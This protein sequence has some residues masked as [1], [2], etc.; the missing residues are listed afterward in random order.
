MRKVLWWGLSILWIA[1]IVGLLTGVF[2]PP[3]GRM[4]TPDMLI[5]NVKIEGETVW[6]GVHILE[7]R[8]GYINYTIEPLENGDFEI[9]EISY[10]AV[11]MMGVNQKVISHFMTIV[12]STLALKSFE[13]FVETDKYAT[14]FS[15]LIEDHVLGIKLTTGNEKTTDKFMP[16]PEPIYISYALKSLMQ[17]GKLRDDDSLK[18][19]SFDPLTM[20][21]RDIMV[22]SAPLKFHPIENQLVEA[23][24][25][26]L[27]TY[28]LE[29]KMYVDAKGE[30][31]LET[32]PMGLTM[33]RESREDAMN[34]ASGSNAK[35]DFLDLFAVKPKGKIN[36]PRDNN[37]L[38]LKVVGADLSMLQSASDRQ[39]IID[40]EKGLAEIRR[41]PFQSG[42]LKLSFEKT[43]SPEPYIESDDLHIIAK[44]QE[45]V[46]G[47]KT[48]RD[49]LDSITKWVFKS[50][51]KKPSAGI[52]SAIAV[53]QELSGDCNEHAVL[54]TALARAVGIPTTVQLGVVYQEDKFF[55]HA[56]TASYVD[57]HWLE[58]DPTFNQTVADPSRIAFAS[59]SMSDAAKLASIIGNLKIDVISEQ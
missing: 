44:A 22:Y 38:T 12:D 4:M 29:T 52:P 1:M 5:K 25:L 47:A 45:L 21:M 13:G 6:L 56:W 50:V 55:Y 30:L 7:N 3:M 59:G 33:K 23:R 46:K 57:G 11:Q 31:L 35:I 36:K 54:F 2:N 8:V 16:A 9:N 39:Q 58:I 27:R 26:R 48:R 24:E 42:N 18:L 53:F 15:G 20:E 28:T 49:S 17:N 37:A 43:T 10:I 32:G 14:K 34:L 41:K 51:A 19:A 40:L